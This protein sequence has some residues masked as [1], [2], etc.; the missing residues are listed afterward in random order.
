MT[1]Q[2]THEYLYAFLD[3]ELDAPL[4]IEFQRHLERCPDCAQQAEIERAIRRQLG[5]TLESQVV[6][7]LADERSLR[8]TIDQV[9]GQ[10]RSLRLFSRRGYLLSGVAAAVIIVVGIWSALPGGHTSQPG[11]AFADLLVK[12]FEHFQQ[13]GR[14]LEIA[15]ADR[16]VVS[17]WLRDKTALALVLPT[18]D[19]AHGKLLGGRKCSL[20]GRP[21]AFALYEIKGVPVSLVVVS[22]DAARIVPDS[23]MPGPDKPHFV[24]WCRG[25]TVVAC[26]RG[27]LTYAAVSTLPAEDLMRLMSETTIEGASTS[28]H[29]G[30]GA[31]MKQR[32]HEQ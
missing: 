28:E 8:H 21:A 18:I 7:P 10:R 27:P 17:D 6:W 11:S 25:H 9:T 12:D 32:G 5:A 22:R 3:S 30:D 24:D 31:P 2:E 16:G 13:K 1:C 20:E 15:S 4:S 19:V 26:T 14:P 23:P 29:D